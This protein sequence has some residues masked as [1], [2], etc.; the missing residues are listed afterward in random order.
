MKS[1]IIPNGTKF[2]HLTV[3]AD[4]GREKWGCKRYLVRCVCKKEIYMRAHDLQHRRNSCGCIR[5]NNLQ[6][7]KEN[8]I[9]SIYLGMDYKGKG[10]FKPKEPK[11]RIF[12]GAPPKTTSGYNHKKGIKIFHESIKSTT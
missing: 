4:G 7:L 9:T 12:K 8:N 2:N 5:R 11:V 6:R 1:V 10:L 3:I